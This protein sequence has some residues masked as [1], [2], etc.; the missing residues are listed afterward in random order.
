[1]PKECGSGLLRDATTP[2]L[3]ILNPAFKPIFQSYAETSLVLEGKA[4]L[5]TIR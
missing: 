4:C 2:R 3:P 1:M 5:S